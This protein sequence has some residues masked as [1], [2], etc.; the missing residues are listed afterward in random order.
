[1]LASATCHDTSNPHALGFWLY[2]GRSNN[3]F[4]YQIV[5][6]QIALNWQPW[7]E[8]MSRFFALLSVRIQLVFS[9][10]QS[11][12]HGFVSLPLVHVVWLPNT[13]STPWV[14]PNGPRCLMLCLVPCATLVCHAHVWFHLKPKVCE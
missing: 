1:M 9:W 5:S 6:V 3:G 4:T 13:Q 12:M 8:Y 2:L 10:N 11:I 14:C 7:Y